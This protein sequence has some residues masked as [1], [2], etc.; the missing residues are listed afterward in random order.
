VDDGNRDGNTTRALAGRAFRHI[1]E[2]F[3]VR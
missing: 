3:V 2:I 1:D